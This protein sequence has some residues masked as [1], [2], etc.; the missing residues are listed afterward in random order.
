[1]R[2]LVF[3]EV[4]GNVLALDAVMAAGRER[5]AEAFLFTGDLVGYGP[6]PL[7]CIERLAALKSSGALAWVTGNH[8]RAVCEEVDLSGCSEEAA[9]TLKWTRRLL[10]QHPDSRQFLE[11]SEETLQVNDR[12]F[13]THD[14]LADPGHAPTVHDPLKARGE[15]AC[16]RFKGGRVGFYGQTHVMHAEVAR[17]NGEVL[18]PLDV[19]HCS[20]GCDPHP[21]RLGPNEIA[22]IGVGSVGLPENERRLP[23]FLILDDV[24]W[25]IEKYAAE[26]DRPAAQARVREVLAPACGDAIAERIARWL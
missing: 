19:P 22:W 21:V 23:E 12:I 18:L 17:A 10:M 4:H 26:Y 25:R 7:A 11:S 5:E 3:G 8:D 24:T 20:E 13:L 2:Y 9:R 14:S 16:L 1:M 6:D 15:L